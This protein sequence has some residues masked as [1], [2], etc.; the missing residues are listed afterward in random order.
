MAGS[1]HQPCYPPA[2]EDIPPARLARDWTQLDLA[3][4]LGVVEG[5]VSRWERGLRMPSEVDRQ[6]LAELFGVDVGEIAFGQVEEQP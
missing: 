1:N 5:T 2:D 4:H 3:L 6:R